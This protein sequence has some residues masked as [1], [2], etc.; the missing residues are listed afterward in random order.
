MKENKIRSIM[1]IIIIIG[2]LIRLMYIMYTPVTERQHDVDYIEDEGHLGYI[3]RIY[4]TGKLPDTNSHQ[5]YHPPLFHYIGA[6][7]LRVTDFFNID[8][9][10]AIE[11]IQILTATFSSLIMLVV[12]EINKE[13]KIKDIYKILILAMIAFHPTFIILAGS[14]N[15]DVLVILFMFIMILYM[16]KWNKNPNIKNTIILALATGLGV[17]TKISAGIMAIPIMYTF[18]RQYIK[19]C[20]ENKK[21]LNWKFINKMVIFG[22]ISL[23]IG[24]WHPIRNLVLFNQQIGGVLVPPDWLDVSKYSLASRLSLVSVRE[25]IQENYAALPGDYNIFAYIVK[26][27]IFG[28]WSY[29]NIDLF[30]MLFKFLNLSLIVISVILSIMC[31]VKNKKDNENNY[32][33]NLLAIIWIINILSYYGFNIQYP[34]ICT[35]DFRY[36]VP[37]IYTGIAL[38]CIALEQFIRNEKIKTIIEN[39]IIIFWV[40]SIVFFFLI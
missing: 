23:P 28:E 18:I 8:Q 17:M 20:K 2:I 22:L 1:I 38:I 24:L 29:E 31:I 35:M 15:N 37:T 30:A 11:G 25:L 3:Y 13:I 40:F 16:I 36:M 5:F 21:I 26:T 9:E 12:Y 19:E 10:K 33:I 6:G 7:W 4:E 34:F 32:F 27:S 14:I 39:L